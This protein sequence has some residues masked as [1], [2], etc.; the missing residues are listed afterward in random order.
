MVT[1]TIIGIVSSSSTSSI[2]ITLPLTMTIIIIIII[3]IIALWSTTIAITNNMTV[4]ITFT[5]I[6]ACATFASLLSYSHVYATVHVA[7]SI[8]FHY[9]ILTV[10]LL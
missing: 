1:I 3:M 4:P 5:D 2:T 9:Y 8:T 7:I 10:I 6:F